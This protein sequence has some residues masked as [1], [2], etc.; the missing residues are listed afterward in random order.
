MCSSDLAVLHGK[1]AE[2]GGIDRERET[3]GAG[4]RRVHGFRHEE[5]ADKTRRVTK[6]AEED[7]I[8]NDT[9]EQDSGALQ[10]GGLHG[11]HGLDRVGEKWARWI[12]GIHPR[13]AAAEAAIAISRA[14]RGTAAANEPPRR[15]AAGCVAWA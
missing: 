7:R 5:I 1:K 15:R 3:N 8:R 13:V 11:F 10:E 9:V 6:R 12:E 14:G 2:Q 4:G